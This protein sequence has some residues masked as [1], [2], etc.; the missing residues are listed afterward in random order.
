[1]LSCNI[2]LHALVGMGQTIQKKLH[3][4]SVGYSPCK[5]KLTFIIHDILCVSYMLKLRS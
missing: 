5:E 1:M 3:K 2:V 4:T